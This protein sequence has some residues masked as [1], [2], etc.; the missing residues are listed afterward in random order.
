MNI[1][2]QVLDSDR[3]AAKISSVLEHVE[4]IEK[5]LSYSTPCKSEHARRLTGSYYTPADVSRFFWNE[6]FRLCK[7]ET[8]D[9]ARY[10]VETH[11]F[12]EPSVGAG[13]LFFSFIEKLFRIGLSP[14]DISPVHFYLVDVNSEA[15]NF[16]RDQVLDLNRDGVLTFRNISYLNSNFLKCRFESFVG[17]PMIFGNPPFI[18]NQKDQSR[19]KNC[20]AD[21]LN[22]SLKIAGEMGSVQLIVPLSLTFSRDYCEL[23]HSLVTNKRAVA[24]SN[25]DNVPDTLF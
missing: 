24:F 1:S 9:K 12:I 3:C 8:P 4:K 21:F 23:R 13:S 16:V 14:S 6:F 15:L 10:F 5:D 20:F 7:I 11:T 25:F 17:A 22:R 2:R 19:W 18:V